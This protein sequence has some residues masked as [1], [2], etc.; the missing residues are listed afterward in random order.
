MK[1]GYLQISF[2]W[3]F[4]IIVGVFIL[5]LAIFASTKIIKTE[6]YEIDTKTAKNLGVLLNPLETSFETGKTNSLTLAAETRIYN[7]CNNKGNF[8]RQLI[9]ISQKSF[10]KWSEPSEEVGFS[11]KYIFSEDY[12]E[13]KKFYLFSKPFDFPFKVSDLIYLTSSQKDYCF[14][15]APENIR[16]ELLSL[17]Q[18]NLFV[19]NCSEESINICFSSGIGCDVFVDYNRKN[20]QKKGEVIYF[21][22]DALMYAGIFADKE[23]YEC[24]IKRLMQ[25]IDQLA[26]L[27]RDKSVFISGKGCNSNLD[28]D[29]VMLSNMANNLEDSANLGT[30]KNLAEEIENKNDLNWECKL[31]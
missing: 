26:L 14:L 21:E 8:G 9:Q 4:A 23:V 7:R 31:W 15:D 17:G 1:R 18:K 6:E 30:I 29:L 28:A 25:R 19:D 13:G 2:A 27:Y 16:D 5:F 12:T 3:L 10:N 22:G 11:N 24:Q 20:I